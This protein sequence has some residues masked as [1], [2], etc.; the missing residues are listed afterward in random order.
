M[1]ESLV[2]DNGVT[3]YSVAFN[4]AFLNLGDGINR[5][6]WIAIILYTVFPPKPY[7]SEYPLCAEASSEGHFIRI[8]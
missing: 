8:A 7:L 2:E 3:V 6:L 1:E 5:M 4:I